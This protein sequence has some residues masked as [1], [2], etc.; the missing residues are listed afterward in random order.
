VQFNGTEYIEGGPVFN[1]WRAPLAN[2]IDPWGSQQFTKTN[3]TPGFG[4]SIDNQL[5]TLGMRDL[6]SEVDEIEV[7]KKSDT[8]I[9]VG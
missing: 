8:K 5:R 7:L 6:I 2:D 4:R 1:V 3:Y 9:I